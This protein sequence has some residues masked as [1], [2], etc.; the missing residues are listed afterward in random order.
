MPKFTIEWG[1]PEMAELWA[2]LSH[3]ADSET[4]DGG[5][6]KLFK[7]LVKTATL[8]ESNPRYPGLQ[9]H[10]IPPLSKRYGIKVWQS[11]LENR[12]PAAGR[13]FW[14]YG[15]ESGVITIIGIEPHPESDKSR[16]YDRVVLSNPKPV[17]RGRGN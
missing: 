15:P 3:K 10:D 14:I 12:K 2:E 6:L 1:V 8:L 17:S 4:L 11:Y 13:L 7:K 9:S 5:E 16:G